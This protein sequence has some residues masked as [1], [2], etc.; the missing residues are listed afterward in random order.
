MARV[1]SLRQKHK[2][3]WGKLFI[4]P[5]IL[6]IFLFV[7]YPIVYTLILSFS[8]Y[9]F[10]FDPAPNIVG[11]RNYTSMFKDK[12]F[13]QALSNTLVFSAFQFA[14]MMV[15]ALLLALMLF[16]VRGRSWLFR[17]SIFMPI[18]VPASLVCLLFTWMLANN[19]GIV[20]RFLI[21]TLGMPRLASNWLTTE[22]TAQGSVIVVSLWNKVGFCTILFLSGLQG[23]SQDVLEAGDIDGATGIKKLRYIILPNLAETYVV[24][25]IWAILQTLKLFVT[26]MVLTKGGPANTTQVLYMYI[27]KTAFL[28]FD[29][30]YAAA[31]SFV[32]SIIVMAFALLNMRLNTRKD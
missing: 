21:D 28:S 32:L 10:V 14:A 20:N 5:A 6:V 25:G 9:N 12:L 30:G 7:V 19:F 27:Y 1:V 11:F 13:L 26:P 17:T 8:E 15:F 2:Q 24:A 4:L 29:M 18:V 16:F 31:M 23:I 3:R 22:R